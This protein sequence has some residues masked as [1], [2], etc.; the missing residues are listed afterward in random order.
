MLV[1]LLLLSA[2]FDAVRGDDRTAVEQLLRQKANPNE[3]D[4]DGA[5]PLSWAVLRANPDIATLLLQAG[6]DPNRANELGIGPLSLAISNGSTPLV[7][8]LLAK[9][10]NPNL[11]RENGETPL[12][13]LYLTMLDKVG[14]PPEK[15]GD[16]TGRL[17]RLEV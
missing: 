13:N 6:A 9:G 3:A 15:L 1:A 2:L 17:N 16:S 10:A 11:A 7:T 5:T 4:N 12:T 14:V 8:Q